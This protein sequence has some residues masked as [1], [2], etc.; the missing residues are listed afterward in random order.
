MSDGGR[1]RHVDGSGSVEV[2][3][4]VDAGRSAGRCTDWLDDLCST[5]TDFFDEIRFNPNS[6]RLVSVRRWMPFGN[7][8]L[9]Q[10]MLGDVLNAE[11]FPQC[12]FKYLRCANTR[13]IAQIGRNASYANHVTLLNVARHYHLTRTS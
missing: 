11:Y 1:E 6:I 13:A 7:H 4:N 8:K 10:S 2:I 3:S 12:G 9:K 5:R